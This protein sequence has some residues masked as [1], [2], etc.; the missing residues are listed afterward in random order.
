MFFHRLAR[1][2][3]WIAM[4]EA[5]AENKGVFLKYCLSNEEI[6]VAFRISRL[7]P[8]WN[9]QINKTKQ[10]TQTYYF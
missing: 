4:D 9:R 6:W 5:Q 7:L 10:K 1:T 3:G 2:V 8:P